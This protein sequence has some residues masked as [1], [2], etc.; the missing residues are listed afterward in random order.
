MATSNQIPVPQG[1][2]GGGGDRFSGGP[3]GGFPGGRPRGGLL[4]MQPWLI[5]L[6]F[7]GTLVVFAIAFSMIFKK[8]GYSGLF[9]L[10]MGVPGL[11]VA[12][13]FFLAL[14]EWPVLKALR[15]QRAIVAMHQAEAATASGD[16]TA[17]ERAPTTASV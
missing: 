13:L 16:V 9:G 15:E 17:A 6:I 14:A 7:V 3:P 5:A 10:L 1:G 8:A 4:L 11:N 12:V 2:F